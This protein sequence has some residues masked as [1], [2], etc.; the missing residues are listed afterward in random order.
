MPRPLLRL[1]VLWLLAL[2]LPLQGAAATLRCGGSMHGAAH[3]AA[4]MHA[5]PAAHAEHDAHAEGT[6]GAGLASHAHPAGHASGKAPSCSACAS[7][8]CSP[9]ALPA[10]PT[11]AL[12]E[13]TGGTMAAVPVVRTPVFLTD[14]PER[15]PRAALA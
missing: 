11:V 1:L 4:S 10:L 3:A 15:P 9:A 2:A 12:P 14:G 8:C 6:T 7:S 5:G 13:P